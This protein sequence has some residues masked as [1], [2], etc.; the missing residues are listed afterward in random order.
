MSAHPHINY[1]RRWGESKTDRLIALFN[2]G[3]S[4]AQIAAILGETRSAVLGRCNRLG[5]R[6][7]VNAAEAGKLGGGRSHK[8]F[9]PQP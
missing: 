5:L 4:A 3:Y 6:R 7:A 2:K 1:Q 8:T 9:V